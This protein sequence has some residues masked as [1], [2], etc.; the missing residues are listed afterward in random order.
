GPV[1]HTTDDVEKDIESIKIF[2]RGIK[3]KYPENGVR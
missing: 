3:G 2:Y 1:F